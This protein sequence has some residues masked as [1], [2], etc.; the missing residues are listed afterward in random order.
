M[1]IASLNQLFRETDRQFLAV[2]ETEL[3]VSTSEVAAI[4]R[5][6]D[7][8]GRDYDRY[9]GRYLGTVTAPTAGEG[10]DFTYI[11][12]N[13]GKAVEI[14]TTIHQFGMQVTEEM[15]DFGRGGWEQYPKLMV[16]V[17]N[18]TKVVQVINLLNRAFD[19]NYPTVY[20]AKELCAT[21][22]PLA[23]GGTGSNEL[24]T[25]SDISE[26]MVEAMFELM[27]RTPDENGV[28]VNKFQG[29]LLITSPSS[30]GDNVRVTQSKFTQSPSDERG[31]NTVSAVTTAYG[32]Q[33]WTHPYIQD[34]DASF[35]L[36]SRYTPL[37][38]IWARRPTIYPGYI[39]QGTRNWVWLSKQQLAV[40]AT[41][42]RGIV[43]TAG[44]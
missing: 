29:N 28:L 40:K 32:I 8:Q 16:E 27:Q 1:G 4:V 34:A 9:A 30:W 20:D 21:D 13:E 11:S 42:W 25:P 19:S 33:T 31:P 43:G 7:L 39:K 35:L 37:E 23:A 18:H 6:R 17:Y 24:A 36:D 15:R 2:F 5:E 14:L 26:A 10:Q 41:E 44:A 22:H 38:V 3:S 12:P